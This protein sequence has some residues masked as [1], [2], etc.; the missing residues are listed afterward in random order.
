MGL[1]LFAAIW[2][3]LTAYYTI[4]LPTLG[5]IVLIL[6][7]RHWW[8]EITYFFMRLRTGFPLIGFIARNSGQR[9]NPALNIEGGAP[10][11]RT[12]LELCSRYYRFYTDT[13]K[14]PDHY[15]RC[16]DYLKKVE[17]SGR[18]PAALWMWGISAILV[19]AE[20]YIFALVLAPFMA[21]SVS[22]NDAEWIALI[23]SVVIS[24]VLLWL[25]HMMGKE[26]HENR[27]LKKAS[28]LYQAAPDNTTESVQLTLE[29]TRQDDAVPRY[30]KLLN[31]VEH[32]VDIA[33]SW[34]W[35]IIACIGIALIAIFAYFIRS[36]TLNEMETELVNA[37]PYAALSAQGEGDSPFSTPSLSIGP[38]TIGPFTLPDEA[39]HDNQQADQRAASEIASER[40]LGYKLTFV[41][42]SVIFIGVQIVGIMI[43][44]TRTFA[45][46]HSRKAYDG[47]G[48]FS[49]RSEFVAWYE[50]KRDRI[51]RDAEM[52][53]SRLQKNI[54]SKNRFDRRD[55]QVQRGN[56][57]LYVR[58]KEQEKLRQQVPQAVQTPTQ[59]TATQRTETS[60]LVK[61]DTAGTNQPPRDTG[62]SNG[63]DEGKLKALGDLTRFTEDQLVSIAQ[64]L[65]LDPARLLSEQ[66]VQQVVAS[67][68]Q[69]A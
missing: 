7:I 27:M 29:E 5:L 9:Q 32:D 21:T 30:L 2:A 58:E 43:G 53:L 54:A 52:H 47:M 10:W 8:K 69:G 42:L 28:V 66:K 59:T 14:D 61:P 11:Y 51:V 3:A 23:I 26:I 22:A 19:L 41:M 48:G 24:I 55:E 1:G 34:K 63:T 37:S 45:G 44:V 40:I 35:T 17:E 60:P 36:T 56:F 49:T 12:E 50:R 64:K 31:R 18:K 65:E 62:H 68:Q 67:V 6:A 16:A 39:E 20:S 4:I 38:V 57:A 15:D 46:V 25:T 33:P 13:Y